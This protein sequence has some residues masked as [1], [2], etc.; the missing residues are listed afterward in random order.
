MAE[1]NTNGIRARLEDAERRLDLVERDV[2]EIRHDFPNMG[3]CNEHTESIA[4]VSRNLDVVRQWQAR[5]ESLVTPQEWKGMQES[6]VRLRME[7]VRFA[8]KLGVIIGVAVFIANL[9]GGTLIVRAVE[10]A[11]QRDIHKSEERI[12]P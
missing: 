6:I 7:N 9:I 5:R 4:V 10:N 12:Q 2:R 3:R 8:V 11:F 1:P